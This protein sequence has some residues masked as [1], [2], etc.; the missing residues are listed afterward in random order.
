MTLSKG[1][2]I[3]G[4]AWPGGPDWSA[5]FFAKI[6]PLENGCWRWTASFRTNGYGQFGLR[7]NDH[8]PAHRLAYETLVAAVPS[9]LVM[10]HLC[11]NVWCVNPTHLEPVT[12]AVNSNRGLNR[13]VSDEVAQLILAA[14]PVGPKRAP[15]GSGCHQVARRYGTSQTTVLRIWQGAVTY[16]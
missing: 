5:R 15:V 7:G 9:E 2:R 4:S 6:E 12:Q 10:D 14:R 13:K 3:Y 11:R 8:R 1:I 16:V